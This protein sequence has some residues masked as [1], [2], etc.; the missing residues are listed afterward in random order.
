MLPYFKSIKRKMKTK[1]NVYICFKT[2][3]IEMNYIDKTICFMFDI[4]YLIS[5]KYL[6]M[7]IAFNAFLLEIIKSFKIILL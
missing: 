4:F 6:F 1:K 7:K 2:R 3:C 5:F